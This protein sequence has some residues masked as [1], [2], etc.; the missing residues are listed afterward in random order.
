MRRLPTYAIETDS[1]IFRTSEKLQDFGNIFKVY[2]YMSMPCHVRSGEK[3]FFA[4]KKARPRSFSFAVANEEKG[5][6]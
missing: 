3:A 1:L 5:D 2:M 6:I 4:D